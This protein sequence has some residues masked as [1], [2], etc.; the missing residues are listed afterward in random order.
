MSDV[1]V[2]AAN[3]LRSAT[4][5]QI[6]HGTI[7]AGVTITQGQTL[8]ISDL[9]NIILADAN[10]STLPKA[11]GFA[12]TAGSP[13]QPIDFVTAD[14]GYIS[15][16]TLTAGDVVYLSENAGHF[17]QTFADINS[18]SLVVALGVVNTNLTLNFLPV[19]GG[20]KP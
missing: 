4:T 1:A 13:G 6:F 12:L 18:A 9:N 7:A 17:T 3:V 2:T 5:I 19:I 16:G 11:V 8:E 10:A 15:G 14:P 20:I